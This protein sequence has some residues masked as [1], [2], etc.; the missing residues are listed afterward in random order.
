MYLNVPED[1]YN[2]N[3]YVFLSLILNTKKDTK[4]GITDPEQKEFVKDMKSLM[5]N[6]CSIKRCKKFFKNEAIKGIYCQG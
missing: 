1:V 5:E 4:L 3:E 2:R 6:G